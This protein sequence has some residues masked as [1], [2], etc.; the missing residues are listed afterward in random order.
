M[1]EL[2]DIGDVVRMKFFV[3][4]KKIWE[5]VMVKEW[6]DERLYIVEIVNGD[7]YC[8]NRFCVRKIKELML[9]MLVF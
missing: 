2:L 5:K 3:V 6:F 9:I 4:G 1:L 8:R 7:M